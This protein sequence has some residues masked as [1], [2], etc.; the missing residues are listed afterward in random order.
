MINKKHIVTTVLICGL[1]L[2]NTAQAQ[3]KNSVYSMFGVGQLTDNNFG[4]NRAFGGTGIAFKSERSI[5]YANPASYLGVPANSYVMEAGLYALYSRSKSKNISES[6]KDIKF[7]YFSLNLY[8][9]DWWALS[10][11]VVP[12]SSVD[13]QINTEDQINGE[14][15]KYDRNYEGSGGLNKLYFG[16]SFKIYKG[17]SAGFNTSYIVGNITQTETGAQN[18]DFAGYKFVKKRTAS[19]LYLDYGM[20][21]TYNHN[22]WSYT[23][24][25][26]YSAKTELNT[27]DKMELTYDGIV[28]ELDDDEVR[29]DIELPQKVGVGFAVKKGNRFRAGIDYQWSDWSDI[30]FY[31]S[32]LETKAAHKFSVGAEYTPDGEG[33]MFS[34]FTYRAGANYTNSYLKVDRT[35][36]NSMAF[37]V[38]IGIP[39]DFNITLEYGEQGTL[40]KGLVKNNY[41]MLY[42]NI[43][44]REFW[45]GKFPF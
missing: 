3:I 11:G 21:Y 44:L 17:L 27:D 32:S 37:D 4:T 39:Y 20:Q 23:L 34:K 35:S 30:R 18:S 42:V 8:C 28:T 45:V 7:S 19:S 26:I 2:I 36:I 5:N 10:F 41:V 38:G 22:N 33:G 15:T 40:E 24:G 1:F 25:G 14:I 12:F 9:A 13:Y 29:D 43:T 6:S 16:N 31:N